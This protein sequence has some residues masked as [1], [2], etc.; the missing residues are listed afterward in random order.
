MGVRFLA[1]DLGLRKTGLAWLDESVGVALP[2]DTFRHKSG[3]EILA[4][5]LALISEKNIDQVILGLPLLPSGDEGSQTEIV[6]KFADRLRLAGA[7]V[8]LQDERYS[9]PRAHST[10]RTGAGPHASNF[11][12]DAAAACALLTSLS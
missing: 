5:V 12:D 7:N 9:T 2:M 3:D 6:K 8:R 11:D 10:R 4:H 1:I